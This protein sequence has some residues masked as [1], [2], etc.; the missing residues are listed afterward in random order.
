MKPSHFIVAALFAFALPL[1]ALSDEA[2]HKGEA[3]AA[4]TSARLAE[5]EVRKIDKETKKITLRHGPIEN[6][7]MP[8][9]S[10]VFQVKDPAMLDQVK[11]G[12]K[13][14]FQAEKV[15]GQFTV[16]RIEPAR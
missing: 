6:L 12:D 15:N 13:V 3:K 7:D 14:R 8:A 9:M 10:M 5:G 4:Q 2:H 1:P 16:T 11:T